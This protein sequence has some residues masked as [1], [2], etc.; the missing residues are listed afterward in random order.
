[1]LSDG[2]DRLGKRT[3]EI[4][5]WVS[6]R[7]TVPITALGTVALNTAANFESA[8]NRVRALTG[9]TGEEL[10]ALEEQA[11]EL[12]RTTQ[13]SASQAA[14]AM[15]FLAMAGFDTNQILGAM[16][17]VLQLAASAQLD[18]ARAADITTNILTGYGMTVEELE[19]A[20]DVLVKSFISAN[21]DLV[22]L[23]EAF[24]YAGPVAKAAG[25]EFEETAALLSM[26]GNAGIQAS[27]AGT[28]LRGAITR[29]LNPT[30]QIQ[31]ILAKYNVRVTDSNGRLR[32]MTRI[33][34]DL[35][36]AGIDAGD[37]M[38]LFG[39]RAGPAMQA[40]IDQG[41]E[42]IDEFVAMLE[43]AGGTAERVGEV[44]MQ[45]LGGAVIRLKSAWEGLM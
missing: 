3:T 29:L 30:K 37:V 42:S 8:M 45:G 38:A 36:N 21:T 18:M 43:E 13:F 39:Q 11:M 14:D 28:S 44:Q 7:L 40:L 16:P 10:A 6:T 25:L 23:G 17:S 32:S 5:K 20:N 1:R 27:M 24:K 41:I 12:G 35:A 22:Q 9:A 15:G 31:D 34:E 2:L 33:L 4:G 26:M 19:R